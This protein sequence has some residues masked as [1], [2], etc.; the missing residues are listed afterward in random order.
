MQ[1]HSAA[2]PLPPSMST[3]RLQA[4]SQSSRTHRGSLFHEAL[5]Q[6]S[7]ENCA[8][9]GSLPALAVAKSAYSTAF[10][11]AARANVLQNSHGQR[12]PDSVAC[13]PAATK[14]VDGTCFVPPSTHSETSRTTPP[15]PLCPEVHHR[16]LGKQ[17][18]LPGYH[19]ICCGS[20]NCSLGRWRS[21]LGVEMRV[22]RRVTR[23]MEVPKLAGHHPRHARHRRDSMPLETMLCFTFPDVEQRLNKRVDFLD[24]PMMGPRRQ[25]LPA[26]GGTRAMGVGQ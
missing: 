23:Q 18:K 22:A 21:Y 19:Y 15:D 6:Q 25:S 5:L 7:C 10:K 2:R 20:R 8:L 11:T 16:H 24:Q 4:S 26:T 14:I 1:R 9:P 17:A 12:M 3:A 13:G